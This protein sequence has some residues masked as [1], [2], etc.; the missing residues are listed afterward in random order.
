MYVYLINSLSKTNLD[1]Q[2]KDKI[3]RELK[4]LRIYTDFIEFDSE[5]SLIDKLTKVDKSKT[6]TLVI[7]G[8]DRDLE[9][10]VGQLG[11]LDGELAIGY[12]PLAESKLAKALNI[13]DWLGGIQ[14]LAQ[15]KITEIPIYSIGSRYFLAKL[16]L[17]FEN[18]KTI[19]PIE[20][21][22]E[23][24]LKL[25][26]PSSTVTIENIANDNYHNKR[27]VLLTAEKA[28]D[29]AASREKSIF[30]L[31]KTTA[32]GKK[33]A[34]EQILHLAVRAARISCDGTIYDDLQRAYRNSVIIG[35]SSKT[36]RLISKKS[37]HR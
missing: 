35:K 10:L 31:I 5:N 23:S 24:K 36:I 20:I 4:K 8:D 3:I 13:R 29:E 1:P 21:L 7:I 19:H 15:R 34:P 26:L 37:L 12:L 25:K 27:P 14:A 6:N 18:Q 28:S 16:S 17:K 11:K 30:K 2:L 22:T 33:T 9:I 32:T